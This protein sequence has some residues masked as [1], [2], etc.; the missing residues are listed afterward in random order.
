ME[1]IDFSYLCTVIGNLSGIPIRV[2]QNE[3]QIFYHSLVHLPI[4]PIT[5][6]K[7][8]ILSIEKHVGYF[9]TPS[10]HYYGIVNGQSY[11]IVIGP[12]ILTKSNDQTLRELA[13]RCDVPADETEEFL[14]GMKSIVTMPLDSIIQML[15]TI[16]YIMNGE[17]FSLKDIWIFDSE[18]Q[19]L[20]TK[21]E[22]AV[23]VLSSFISFFLLKNSLSIVL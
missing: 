13:F 4:D 14:S 18:Q 16:N 12:S 11:K 15:C 2:F 1:Q 5:P 8:E 3:K 20:K 10:F 21:F 19:K 23:I 9:I 7:S 22:E 6:Y 17:K